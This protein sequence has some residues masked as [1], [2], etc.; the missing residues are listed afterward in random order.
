MAITKRAALRTG[1]G[2]II[3]LLV[4]S[5]VM[6]YRIQVSFS[7]RSEEIHR[8][9]VQQQELLTT[10]R[11]VL[12]LAGTVSR[13]YLISPAPN[14]AAQY[15]L[16]ISAL[17][18]EGNNVL[19]QLRRIPDHSHTV[20]ALEVLLDDLWRTLLRSAAE[21][22]WDDDSKYRFI[23]QQLVPRRETAD[24]LV[25]ELE[26]ASHGTLTE[27]EGQFRE[28]RTGATRHL[29]IM[30]GCSLLAGFLVTHFSVRYS[31]LL[32]RQAADQFQQVSEAKQELERLSARLMEIQEEER[33]RLSRELHDE[34]VQN[35]AVLKMEI[36]QAQNLTA[37]RS[38]EARDTLARARDLAERTVRTVRDISVL[39]RP[40]LLD[41]LGLGPALQWQAEDFTRRTGVPCEFAEHGVDESLP[42][43]VKTCVYRV[44]QEALRNSEKHS[45]ASCV[46]VNLA[47]TDMEVCAEIEDNGVGFDVS[48]SVRKGPRH[49]GLLGMRERAAAA[50]GHLSTISKDGN[51]TKIVLSVPVPS[52]AEAASMETYA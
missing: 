11:R 30:L 4:L 9:Y 17:Q 27:S 51:G 29:L 5:T 41:D 22:A 16:Q 24:M 3:G 52:R 15:G 42:D 10:L 48:G 44:V 36:M 2:I 33:T 25:R 43:A 23:R 39:L 50:G 6:A 18:Q 26:R 8:R 37:V 7:D 12:A 19:V 28:T 45:R 31:E 40:S 21:E 13:D 47:Q 35:L 1:F 14:R 20:A 38:P 49:L 46:K 34:I 32:E